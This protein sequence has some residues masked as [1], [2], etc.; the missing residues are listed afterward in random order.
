MEFKFVHIS[1]MQEEQ[2]VTSSVTPY[3]FIED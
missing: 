2:N 1:Q 3:V